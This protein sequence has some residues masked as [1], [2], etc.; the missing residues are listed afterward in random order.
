MGQVH[1][2]KKGLDIR[3]VGE[4]DKVV[5]GSGA[6]HTIMVSPED[7]FGIRP[8]TLVNA[9][10]EVLAGTPIMFDKNNEAHKIVSPVSGEVIEV[11]RGAKRKL[12]GIKILADKD[13]RY[14]EHGAI[15]LSSISAENL[16]EKLCQAGLWSGIKMRPYNAIA[17]PELKPKAV[18]ISAF[19]SAPLAPDYDFVVQGQEA[20]FELGL[21]A[22]A[23]VSGAKVH[24]G[25]HAQKTK[26][27][28]FLQTK[29]AQVHTFDGPH[30]S[31]L[32]STQIG[33][34]SPVNRGEVV[35]TSSVQEVIAIGKFIQTG[36]FDATRLVALTGGGLK[37]RKYARTIGGASMASLVSDA[38]TNGDHQRWISGN[39]FTGRKV[40]K[41]GYLGYF[42]NQVTLIEEGGEPEFFGWIAPGFNKF[43]LSRTFFSWAMPGKKYNLNTSMN[44]EERAFVVT[45]EYEKVFPLDILPVQL[46]KAIL[47]GD[48]EKQEQL[49]IYEVVPEDFALCEFVCTSKI[50]SQAIVEGAMLQLYGE[51]VDSMKPE[52]HHHG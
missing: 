28:A 7:F 50:E 29:A 12:L 15:S 43:S 36:R 39:V 19:D 31:G 25:V 47:T 2:I 10:D 22:L 11:V 38:Q 17:F 30:P 52:E 14:V 18:F 24:L 26:S 34:I 40:S 41:E 3:L 27:A 49:G 9:G 46:L 33:L 16:T 23:K 37:E 6:L 1:K 45:G 4:A 44:G 51:L 21:Q 13:I 48:I 32:L 35:W 5:V 8:K 20:A 42:E